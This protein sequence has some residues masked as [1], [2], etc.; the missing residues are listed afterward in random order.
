MTVA[1][2]GF[3]VQ[4]KQAEEA[5]IDL[6]KL[7]DSAGKAQRGA[8]GVTAASKEMS[9]SMQAVTAILR[10]IERHTSIMAAGFMKGS[11]AMNAVDGAA[12]R[13]GKA[14]DGASRAATTTEAATTGMTNATTG[15]AAAVDR[16]VVEATDATRVV[17]A[18]GAANDRAATSA[19][20]HMQAI[21]QLTAAER[22]MTPGANTSRG[23]DIDAYGAELD[24]LRAKYNPVFAVSKAYEAELDQ[25]NF[26]HRVG[27]I[28]AQEQAA[29]LDRL[30]AQYTAQVGA[31]NRATG[32]LDMN[33]AAMRRGGTGVEA[34]S[35]QLRNLRYQLFDVA[36]TAALGMNPLLILMQQGPQIA[37]IYGPEEGGVARAFQ[38]TGTMLTRMVVRA[39]PAIAVIGTLTVGVAALRSEI[40]E[41][42]G[43]TVSMGDTMLAI[44]QMLGSGIESAFK[45]AIETV[46][47]LFSSFWNETGDLARDMFNDMARSGAAFGSSTRREIEVLGAYWNAGVT[48]IKRAWELLPGALGDLTMQ[49]VNNVIG[50]IEDMVNGAISRINALIDLVNKIPGVELGKMSTVTLGR[51]Q[52]IFAGQS[53]S[54]ANAMASASAE[55]SKA[56]EKANADHERRMAGIGKWD[57]FGDLRTRAMANDR[58]NDKPDKGAKK[59]ADEAARAAEKIRGEMQS[60]QS[61]VNSFDL[62]KM[63][64]VAQAVAPWLERAGQL[65]EAIESGVLPAKDLANAHKLLEE[66][67]RV[68]AQ[69]ADEARTKLMGIGDELVRQPDLLR[70]EINALDRSQGAY[71][72]LMDARKLN[73]DVMAYEKDLQ[74]AVARGYVIQG[75]TVEG[76]VQKYRGLTEERNAAAVVRDVTDKVANDNLR[77]QKALIGGFMSDVKYGLQQGHSAW[78]AFGDAATRALDRITNKALDDLIDKLLEVQNVGSGSGGKGGLL[79]SL[80]S[81]GF[82]FV[83]GL[84]G[85]STASPGLSLGRGD[86]TGAGGAGFSYTS[87]GG[88]RANGGPVDPSRWYMVGE[89]GP[90]RFQP[91]VPGR[92]IPNHKLRAA[93]D[94][95]PMGA[96]AQQVA[97]TLTLSEDLNARM[98]QTAENV[99][100][101]VVK[102]KSPGIVKESVGAV[103]AANQERPLR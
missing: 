71:D 97:L 51:P 31:V 18:M 50:G 62:S 95:S 29:A 45:P 73:A 53:A 25:I 89:N 33:N 90:E 75:D 77:E 61:A 100:V 16:L 49:T 66:T 2:L 46:K 28:T 88:P 42:K 80:I 72:R 102:Q 32:A 5:A 1:R 92:I 93:N 9:A 85:G 13:A 82:S 43:A 22:R 6:D 87:Y 83:T 91:D 26:A 47:A 98:T 86:T 38:E 103:Y 21:E 37:Q 24:R 8:R 19:M 30:N 81:Q 7:T 36:Q 4:S 35:F 59:A 17:D 74:D 15:A 101:R 96:Q 52:N 78:E 34:A 3:E 57:A 40:N 67:F 84:F 79:G 23:T 68:A 60:I 70:E 39:G 65:R 58:A 69:A 54:F 48:M 10:D 11:G 76:L 56:V 94:A 14:L 44:F 20:R 63:G 41:T 27:A 64:D 99:S 55:A 12:Q